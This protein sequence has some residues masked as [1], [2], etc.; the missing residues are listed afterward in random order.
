MFFDALRFAILYNIYIRYNR[1]V[2][3][4]IYIIYIV[5]DLSKKWVPFLNYLDILAIFYKDT[6]IFKGFKLFFEHFISLQ[7]FVYS[8]YD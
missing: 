3:D 4:Y 7:V 1:K 5:L 8:F 6:D 2:I